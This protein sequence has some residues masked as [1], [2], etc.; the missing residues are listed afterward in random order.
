VDHSVANYATIDDRGVIP[1]VGYGF[2]PTYDNK[3]DL[4]I[5]YLSPKDSKAR[6]G[7]LGSSSGG[8]EVVSTATGQGTGTVTVG[9]KLVWSDPYGYYDDKDDQNCRVGTSWSD[10]TTSNWDEVP[11][12]A[13]VLVLTDGPIFDD[14]G[15][16][17]LPAAPGNRVPKRD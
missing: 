4:N 1:I 17:V 3:D 10:A 8:C 2:T 6:A 11:R 16:V 13:T 9:L 14:G 15:T 7:D 12:G 5:S